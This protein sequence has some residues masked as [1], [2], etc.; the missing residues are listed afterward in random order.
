M[1]IA[2]YIGSAIVDGSEFDNFEEEN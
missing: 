2:G 1:S